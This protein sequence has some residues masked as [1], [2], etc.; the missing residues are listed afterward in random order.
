MITNYAPYIET[1]IPAFDNKQIIVPFE[2]N[3]AVPDNGYRLC[4]QVLEINSIT[5][6]FSLFADL[7]TKKGEPVIFTLPTDINLN[8][9]QFYYLRLAY[10]SGQNP[11]V[12]SSTAVSRYIGETPSIE[13]HEDTDINNQTL[14][15]HIMNSDESILSIKFFIYISFVQ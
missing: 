4:L 15:T 5:P 13:F 2:R 11:G 8:A 9:G 14:L 1:T 3:P 7:P 12:F 6:K 10:A